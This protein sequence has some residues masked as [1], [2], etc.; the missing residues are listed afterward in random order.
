MCAEA[1]KG[2]SVAA[3]QWL[4][5]KGVSRYSEVSTCGLPGG[6]AD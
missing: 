4:Q 6:A 2:G 5:K 3:L 1:A